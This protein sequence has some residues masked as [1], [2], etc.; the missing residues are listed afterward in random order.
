MSESPDQPV[1]IPEALDAGAELLAEAQRILSGFDEARK[2]RVR[3]AAQRAVHYGLNF[4]AATNDQQRQ[5]AREGLTRERNVVE[6]E[7]YGAG[8]DRLA[9]LQRQAVSFATTKLI[10]ALLA[11]EP[12]GQTLV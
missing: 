3:E 11:H 4:A 5:R 6:L 10:P 8:L 1:T 2:A 9:T 7:L 12:G